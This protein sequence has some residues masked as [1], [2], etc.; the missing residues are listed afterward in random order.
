MINQQKSMKINDNAMS[1]DEHILKI[2]ELQFK[3][4]ELNEIDRDVYEHQ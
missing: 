3:S 2:Y 4:K 1:I